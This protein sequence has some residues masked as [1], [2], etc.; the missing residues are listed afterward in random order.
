MLRSGL[1]HFESTVNTESTVDLVQYHAGNIIPAQKARI[2]SMPS[3]H[4]STKPNL[5]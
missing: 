2:V 3:S 4:S 1:W 5:K